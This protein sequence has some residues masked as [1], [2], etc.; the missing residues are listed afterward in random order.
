MNLPTSVPL[1]PTAL[2]RR[3]TEV[4]PAPD[5]APSPAPSPVPSPVPSPAPAPARAASEPLVVPELDAVADRGPYDAVAEAEHRLAAAEQTLLAC[6]D[7]RSPRLRALC[8]TSAM[9]LIRQYAA[10]VGAAEPGSARRGARP[11]RRLVDLDDLPPRARLTA[12]VAEVLQAEASG[13]PMRCELALRGPVDVEAT[14]A[15]QRAAL[16]ATRAEAARDAGRAGA[17]PTGAV[18]AGEVPTGEVPTGEVPAATAEL[19]ERL[20]ELIARN[21]RAMTAASCTGRTLL[22]TVA[23]RVAVLDAGNAAD[24]ADAL[25]G[26]LVRWRARHPLDEDLVDALLGDYRLGDRSPGDAGLGGA[27]SV[28][29]VGDVRVVDLSAGEAVIDLTRRA[30]A[31]GDMACDGSGDAFEE[32]NAWFMARTRTL[33]RDASHEADA[34]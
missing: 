5:P 30:G 3:L 28:P 21:L 29:V 2:L 16:R 17:V 10:A 31:G 18:P 7:E 19:A 8:A 34:G 1:V 6:L 12:R 4:A 33:V 23:A 11:R 24:V 32:R 26:M 20:G 15:A 22:R 9:T 25:H 27:G 14:V 13:H